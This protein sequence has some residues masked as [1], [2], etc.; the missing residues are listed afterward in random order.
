MPVIGVQKLPALGIKDEQ[1][2]VEQ[3]HGVV[4]HRPDVLFRVR[5]GVG[6]LGEK[7][8]RQNLHRPVDIL[9]EVAADLLGIGQALLPH[10]VQEG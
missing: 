7:A 4:L 10:P 5:Q 3:A 1:H 2:P 6:R 9:L 8:L